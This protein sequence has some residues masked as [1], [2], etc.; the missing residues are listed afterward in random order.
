MVLRSFLG[1]LDLLALELGLSVRFLMARLQMLLL[2]AFVMTED[3][4]LE[5]VMCICLNALEEFQPEVWHGLMHVSTS[6]N[7][8]LQP[9]NLERQEV[10]SEGGS[11]ASLM[12]CGMSAWGAGWM[13]KDGLWMLLRTQSWN[14]TLLCLLTLHLSRGRD[15]RTGHPRP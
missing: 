13:L 5:Q 8:F 10:F 12:S 2:R 14:C 11:T 15:C 3:F 7:P 1:M 4:R 6:P 9:P